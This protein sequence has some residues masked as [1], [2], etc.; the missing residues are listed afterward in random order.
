MKTGLESVKA[1][2]R[3]FFTSVAEDLEK[4]QEN[5]KLGQFT[6]NREQPRGVTQII[7][8]TIFALLP[9]LSSLFE[10][11]GQ[12]MFGEDLMCELGGGVIMLIWR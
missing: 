7:N 6:H 4:T 5:L 11:I 12:N 1:A 2:L 8:Y 9:V 3:S 10:H